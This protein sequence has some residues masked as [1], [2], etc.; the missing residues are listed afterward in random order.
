MKTCKPYLTYCLAGWSI[1]CVNHF[2]KPP[3]LR[4][5]K[6]EGERLN[7]MQQPEQNEEVMR[8]HLAHLRLIG[9]SR[10]TEKKGDKS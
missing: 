10:D 6:A 4:L 7:A 9:V 1:Q 3:Q 5:S 2:P 8:K